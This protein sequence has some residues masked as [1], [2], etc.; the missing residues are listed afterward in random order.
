MSPQSIRFSGG[1][2]NPKGS[3]YELKVNA[4]TGAIVAIIIGF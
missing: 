3:E 4:G 1:L 2:V